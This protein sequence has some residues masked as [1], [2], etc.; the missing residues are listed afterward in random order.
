MLANIIDFVLKFIPINYAK[1]ILVSML[2]LAGVFSSYK[3]TSW[4]YSGEIEKLNSKVTQYEIA[5]SALAESSKLQNESIQKL[6][7]EQE[8]KQKEVKLAQDKAKLDSLIY[9]KKASELLQIKSE[10]KSCSDA[11][12]LIDNALKQERSIK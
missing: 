6:S 1:I 9:K 11:S 2:V 7:K 8:K 5:Y 3:I 12:A 4:Y 10:G